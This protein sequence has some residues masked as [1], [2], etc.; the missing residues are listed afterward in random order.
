M[1]K[2]NEWQKERERVYNML[3]FNYNFAA[4]PIQVIAN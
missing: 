2:Q 1:C 4:F 3:N